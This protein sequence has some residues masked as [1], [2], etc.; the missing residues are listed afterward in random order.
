[1]HL[2]ATNG[3]SGGYARTGHSVQAVAISGDG[4]GMERDYAFE[5]RVHRAEL[6]APAEIG[7]LAGERTAARAGARKPPTGAFPVLYDERVASGLIG[8]LVQAINGTAIARGASWLK[9]ALGERVLPAGI[10]LVEDPLRPRI[11]GSRPFDGEGLPVARRALVEDGVL[12]GWTLDLATAR[13]LG[14]KSTGNAARGTSAPPSPAAG[15]LALTQGTA[16]RDELIAEMGT[17]LIVTELLGASINPTTGDYS[18]GAGGFWVENGADRA[19]GQRVHDRR[20]PARDARHDPA[21]ERRAALARPG[22]AEPPGRGAGRC[23]KLTSRCS[24]GRR[25]RRA[26]S[27]RGSSGGTARSARSRAATGRSAPP[28]SP[29]TGCFARSSRAARP[30][31]GW[32]SEESEDGPERLARIPC[33]RR[34]PDRRHPRLRR[35]REGLGDLARGGRGRPAGGRRRPPAAARANLRRRPGAG[36]AAERHAA[37]A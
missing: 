19:A 4:T 13:Q 6:P 7:R 2:A 33:L 8:H 35:R 18:R 3:F 17:G 1:M 37:C 12:M 5:A 16:S 9:D 31:Y 25:G 29:S 11:G 14:L 10:D 36:G 32:L 22:G 24:S 34:R 20:Q 26:S 21:G 15:N 27:R 28:T 23:R 30:D